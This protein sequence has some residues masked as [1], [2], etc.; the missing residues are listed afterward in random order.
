MRQEFRQKYHNASERSHHHAL[1]VGLGIFIVSC[2]TFLQVT[3]Q[4]EIYA[5]YSPTWCSENSWAIDIPLSECESLADL[6]VATNGDNRNNNSDWFSGTTICENWYGISCLSNSVR[7]IRLTGNNLSGVL[8][9]SLSWLSALRL[10]ELS[11]NSLYGEIPEALWT[12]WDLYN[13]NFDENNFSGLLSS[14]F[15]GVPG[16]ISL[17]VTHNANLIIDFATFAT[18]NSGLTFLQINGGILTWDISLIGLLTQLNYLAI[19]AGYQ[20]DASAVFSGV[21]NLHN[22]VELKLKNLHLSGA[23]PNIRTNFPSLQKLSLQFND[24]IWPLP[25]SFSALTGLTNLV[26]SFNNFD[27][28]IPTYF[29]DLSIS[30]GDITTNCFDTNVTDTGLLTALDNNFPWWDKQYNCQT[31]IDMSTS[32]GSSGFSAGMCTPYTLLYE[33]L[34]P[35]IAKSLKIGQIFDAPLIVSWSTPSY[36]TWIVG[37]TYGTDDDPC[38]ADAAVNATGPYYAAIEALVM[39]TYPVNSLYQ[40]AVSGLGFTGSPG[41]TEFAYMMDTACPWLFSTEDKALC[42]LMFWEDMSEIDP[43]CGTGGEEWYIWRLGDVVYQA[44]GDIVV[45]LCLPADV[46]WS[47]FFST[48]IN[49]LSINTNDDDGLGYFDF[50]IESDE[51]TGDVQTWSLPPSPIPPSWWWGWGSIRITDEASGLCWLEKDCSPSYYD[52]TCG[53]CTT[54][55]HNS[56]WIKMGELIVDDPTAFATEIQK[57][58]E[59]MPCTL[60]EQLIEAYVFSFDLGITTIPKI[61]NA[62]LN[63]APKRKHLA[64]ILSIFAVNVLGKQADATRSCTFTDMGQES[65]EFKT[66]VLV[67]CKLW[68]MGL[69]RDGTPDTKFNPNKTVT[70]AEFGAAFSRLLYWPV[71]NT[72][73]TDPKPWYDSHLKALKQDAIMTDI[74]SPSAQES[75]WRVMLMSKRAYEEAVGK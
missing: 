39:D 70:R 42:F 14:D 30:E 2:M 43:S 13:V 38:Y 20:G 25:S 64:K 15:S 12:L 23:L 41:T 53:V 54:E 44:T 66:F 73:K 17:S 24:F 31:N 75:R 5:S 48:Q 35:Q 63:V 69:K 57:V 28:A 47:I 50:L 52:N 3:P 72:P 32:I 33:N 10:L 9:T 8:P 26:L 67:S 21:V 74:D 6:Y 46:T 22:L 11:Y 55:T 37:A 51:D 1:I 59:D 40:M 61:C 18:L 4:V 60:N 16:L 19:D 71:N 29:A 45:D 7:N 68:L 34:G 56:P 58:K 49:T 65:D 62:G 36:A 27:G